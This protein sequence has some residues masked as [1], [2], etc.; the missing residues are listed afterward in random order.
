MNDNPPISLAEKFARKATT[1]EPGL[2]PPA[3]NLEPAT[4]DLAEGYQAYKIGGDHRFE[5]MVT[6]RLKNGNFR[7]LGYSYLIGLDF[8]PS[9]QLVMEFTSVTVTITGR[10]L[11]PLFKA[12][13]AHKVVWISEVDAVSEPTEDAATVVNAISFGEG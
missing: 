6:F 2:T 8:N 3:R 1:P 9:K 4:E 7:A 13:A 12:L 10:N 5:V 11:T